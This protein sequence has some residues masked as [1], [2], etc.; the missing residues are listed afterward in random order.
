MRETRVFAAT[1]AAKEKVKNG[2]KPCGKKK[3][4]ACGP[5]K[6]G[7]NTGVKPEGEAK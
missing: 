4:C 2:W 5:A 1:K 3:G 6:P 7:A